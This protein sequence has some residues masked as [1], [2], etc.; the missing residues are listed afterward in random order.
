MSRQIQIRRGSSAEHDNFT[1]AIGEITMD[2]TNNNLRVHD[3]ST[4]GGHIIYNK[5]DVD[6]ALSGKAETATTLSGY[7]ITDGVNTALSNLTSAGKNVCA[8]MMLP[9]TSRYIELTL[10]ASETVYTAPADGW[11]SFD[12]RIAGVGYGVGLVYAN[13][14]HFESRSN[15]TASN[16]VCG[17]VIPVNKGQIITISYNTL[18]TTTPRANLRFYYA[19][20]AQ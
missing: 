8:S 13:N 16:Q 9:D 1:G 10:G 12:A 11:F 17:V 7:G 2:T 19:N 20:G 3:G 6:T 4:V 14:A 18:A 5:S 15:C